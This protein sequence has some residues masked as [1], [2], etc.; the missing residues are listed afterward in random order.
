MEPIEIIKKYLVRKTSDNTV[1]YGKL[2]PQ[3]IELEDAILGAILLESTAMNEVANILHE[4]CFYKSANI[5]IW[6]AAKTIY[7][8]QGQIDIL[9]VYEKIKNNGNPFG[10]EPV[11]LSEL[12]GKVGSSAH[13]EEH[14][15]IIKEKYLQR[16][17]IG[18]QQESIK[19]LYEGADFFE[20]FDK[21]INE[22]TDITGEI[23]RIQQKAFADTVLERVAEIRKAG[24]DHTYRTGVRCFLECLDRQTMGFQRT[25]LIIVAARPSMGKTAL[26]I[27]LCRKQIKNNIPVGFFSLEMSTEQIVDRMLAGES[28]IDMRQISR[29]G[30]NQYDWQKIDTATTSL[31]E[32]PMFVCDKGGLTINE[33][34]GIAKNWKI[35]NKIE[36]LY[37]DYLQLISSTEKKN[38]NREQEVSNI[39]RRLKQLAKEL[40]IPVVA[41]SQLSRACEARTD[42]RPELSDLR[43]SGSIEQDA[44]MVIF[45]FREEYYNE[46]AEKGLCELNIKKYRNGKVGLVKSHFNL[47]T[48]T[49]TDYEV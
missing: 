28:Q 20:E 21:L 12:I 33:I 3:A 11:Y 25:D 43:E 48:Q 6:I 44:D 49:F 19:N 13:I 2:P 10:I 23:N 32:Y 24:T 42:K 8:E 45:P 5:D 26:A 41:L 9:T 46:G 35:K 39:S 34:V 36:I 30:M 29:G 4:R 7:N 17:L 47:E 16:R 1:D 14:A 22:I 37:V 18:I 31:I 40:H 38:G 27:D 15:L